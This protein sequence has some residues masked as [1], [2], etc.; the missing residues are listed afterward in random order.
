MD[1]VS[2]LLEGARR[3][4]K[5]APD[6]EEKKSGRLQSGSLEAKLQNQRMLAGLHRVSQ[7]PASEIKMYV[8]KVNVHCVSNFVAQFVRSHLWATKKLVKN[9]CQFSVCFLSFPG[10][11]PICVANCCRHFC[12]LRFWFH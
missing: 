9:C 3:G 11:S 12:R 10:L 8:D 2:D 7:K 5:R 4:C 1:F 6:G